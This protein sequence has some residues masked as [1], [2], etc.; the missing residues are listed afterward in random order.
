MCFDLEITKT[1]LL[2]T[3]NTS[4]MAVISVSATLFAVS[5]VLSPSAVNDPVT[6]YTRG[7][8]YDKEVTKSKLIYVDVLVLLL[9]ANA[10]Y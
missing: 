8:V 10:V 5:H 9:C 7:E 6:L 1:L 4:H 2:K 3:T